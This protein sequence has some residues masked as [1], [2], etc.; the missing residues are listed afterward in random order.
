ME[1]C[2]EKCPVAEIEIFEDREIVE[3]DNLEFPWTRDSLGYFILRIIPGT[4]TICCG[5]VESNHKMNLEFRGEDP[6]KIIKEINKREIC[7]RENL[8]YIA[9]EL[10]L[11]LGCIKE[12]R[13][14]VQR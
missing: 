10:M 9:Q 4:K 12:G 1:T 13:E 6:D 11:A 5:F 8:A 3:C 2:E 14:Y 7:S